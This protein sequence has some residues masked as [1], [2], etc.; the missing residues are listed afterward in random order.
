MKSVRVSSTVYGD[1]SNVFL[2][3]S[4]DKIHLCIGSLQIHSLGNFDYLIDPPKNSLSINENY[5]DGY[6]ASRLFWSLENPKRKTVYHLKIDVEQNYHQD[7]SQHVTTSFP[8]T[9]EQRIREQIYQ[10]CREYFEKYQKK[11]D[12]HSARIEQFCQR[13]MVQKKGKANENCSNATTTAT[14][15]KRTNQSKEKNFEF[16]SWQ[17]RYHE[18]LMKK[19]ET[20]TLKKS[21]DRLS[22]KHEL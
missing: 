22:V 20:V 9:D 6:Q 8:M 4:L 3:F 7:Q 14:G 17:R 21:F 15:R 12:E 19:R 16:S 5:P 11:I 1:L 13:T 18:S 2:D 10:T